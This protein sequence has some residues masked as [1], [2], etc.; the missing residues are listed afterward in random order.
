MQLR[1]KNAMEPQLI[2]LAIF[3][4]GKMTLVNDPLKSKDAV[5][6]YIKKVPRS[7]SRRNIIN[8]ATK[9][10]FWKRF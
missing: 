10:N 1:R 4:E 8:F 2:D 9:T 3:V 5:S 7:N 6:Q